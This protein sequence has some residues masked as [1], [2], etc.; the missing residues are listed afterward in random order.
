M[1]SSC[2]TFVALPPATAEGCVV[3]GKNSDRPEDE[4][5]EVVYKSAADHAPGSVVSC[6]YIDIPQVSHTFAV[7]LSKPAWMWGA[8][9]GANE[10]GVAIGN[11]AVWTRFTGMSCLIEKLLGMDYVRLG[12]ERGATARQAL[13]VITGLLETY[14]QGG[15]CYEDPDYASVS[16]CNSFII[17]DS[18]EAWV[19]ET[20]GQHWAAER[21]ENGVRNI[22]NLLTIETKIDA[23]SN[24]LLDVAQRKGFW[25]PDEGPFN[26]AMAFSTCP[27]VRAGLPPKGS[28]EHR[29]LAGKELLEK[30]S[31]NGSFD[32]SSMFAILRDEDSCICRTDISV[33]VGSQVSL[34]TPSGSSKANI[35]W[36]TATPNPAR[37]IYKPFAFAR[38]VDIG[39]LSVSPDYGEQ[40]PVRERPRFQRIVDR[41]H[42]LYRAHRA[43]SPLGGNPNVKL[44]ASLKDL[45]NKTVLD[46]MELSDGDESKKRHLFKEALQD[47][48]KIYRQNLSN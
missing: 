12:L 34:L 36:F 43:V 18:R 17:A 26:F 14:G 29:Y 41:S 24:G 7:V 19:L 20:A 23:M 9:M 48:L 47:E 22:S 3:F 44:L 45:E 33:S 46:V 6:T 13:D 10:H 35:H 42:E 8:E 25:E 28:G 31:Q 15:R 38:D 40:D 4:V 39:S 21:V 1:L 27:P 30:L 16:Y 11:E 2:D 5:Q 37:S 32:V